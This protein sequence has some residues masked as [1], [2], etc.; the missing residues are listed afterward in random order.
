M[1]VFNEGIVVLKAIDELIGRGVELEA[2]VDNRTLFNA[3][4]KN[5]SSAKWR[6]KINVCAIRQCYRKGELQRMGRIRGTKKPLK[7]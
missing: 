5:N 1:Y 4:A 3:V 2:F 6:S 7:C